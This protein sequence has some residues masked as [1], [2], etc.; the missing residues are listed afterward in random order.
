MS[1]RVRSS[2]EAELGADR[3]RDYEVGYGKPPKATQFKKGQSGNPKGRK[4]ANRVEDLRIVLEK[5]LDEPIDLRV[6]GRA[7]TMT[8]LEAM[9]QAQLLNGLKGNPKAVA[10]LFSLAQKAG[11]FTQAKPRGLLQITEPDGE[12]GSI[13]RMFNAER[14]AARVQKDKTAVRQTPGSTK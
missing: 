7:Q 6:G 9:I 1:D 2:N 5:I 4:K 11:M 14:D 13:V 8:K 3:K 12:M 10:R